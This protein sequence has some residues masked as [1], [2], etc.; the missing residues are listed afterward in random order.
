MSKPSSI[1]ELFKEVYVDK[2]IEL[3]PTTHILGTWLDW[4]PKTDKEIHDE[5]FGV[6]FEDVLNAPE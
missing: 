3:I 6:K 1:N 4:E 5:G 2:L